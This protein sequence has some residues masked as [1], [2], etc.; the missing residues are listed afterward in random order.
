MDFECCGTAFHLKV[1]NSSKGKNA[2]KGDLVLRLHQGCP[3]RLPLEGY[4]SVD[5]LPVNAEF[6]EAESKHCETATASK[7]Y[8]D[9]VSKNGKHASGNF[10]GDF[11]NIGHQEGKFAVNYHHEGPNISAS[12]RTTLNHHAF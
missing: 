9:S 1:R 4:V 12:N 8:L 5:R 6:C 2:A 11:P 10:S 7:I 3:G